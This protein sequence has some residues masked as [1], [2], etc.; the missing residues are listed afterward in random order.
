M[1]KCFVILAIT[2]VSISCA[3]RGPQIP[4]Q[5]PT[6][7]LPQSVTVLDRSTLNP[8]TDETFDRMIA[9]LRI[10]WNFMDADSVSIR[11][12][13]SGQLNYIPLWGVDVVNNTLV[14][15]LEDIKRLARMRGRVDAYMFTCSLPGLSGE[16]RFQ[17]EGYKDNRIVGSIMSEPVTIGITTNYCEN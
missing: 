11:A 10:S 1:Y 15:I 13:R 7:T 14:T 17:I 2:A 3:N 16:W 5:G 8:P 12:I 4:L 6:I 9:A